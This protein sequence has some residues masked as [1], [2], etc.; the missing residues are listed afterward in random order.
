MYNMAMVLEELL[1]S[2]AGYLV[3]PDRRYIPTPALREELSEGVPLDRIFET[4]LDNAGLGEDLEIQ[5]E[6]ANGHK[7][8]AQIGDGMW[9]LAL[10]DWAARIGI[11]YRDDYLFQQITQAYRNGKWMQH[12]AKM[13]GM[14]P[15]IEEIKSARNEAV[16]PRSYSEGLEA[17]LGALHHRVNPAIITHELHRLIGN[18]PDAMLVP[19]RGDLADIEIIYPGC[20]TLLVKSETGYKARIYDPRKDAVILEVTSNTSVKATRHLNDELQNKAARLLKI[21][22]REYLP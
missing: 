14:A 18:M 5:F 21:L 22:G 3:N 16:V 12:V 19:M 11:P 8:L 4:L 2:E 9:Q 17:W 1:S 13:T 6:I 15:F 7:N 20:K 10:T